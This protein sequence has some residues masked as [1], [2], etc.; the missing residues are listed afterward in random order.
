MLIPK[1]A[2]LICTD[3]ERTVFMTALCTYSELLKE[4]KGPVLEGGGHCDAIVNGT[5]DVMTYK[6]LFLFCNKFIIHQI[7]IGQ[8][9]F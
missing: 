7:E 9:C 2:K 4:I 6:V 3:E 5:K 8:K 1:C